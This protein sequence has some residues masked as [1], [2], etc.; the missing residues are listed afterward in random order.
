MHHA[1]R[2]LRFASCFLVVAVAAVSTPLAHAQTIDLSLNVFYAVPSNANSG[3]TWELV[4][5]SSNFGIAT[6]NAKII[7][8]NNDAVAEGPRGNVNGSDGAGFSI[9]EKFPSG[10]FM[11]QEPLLLGSGE[12]QGA[13][14]GV[15]TIAN[16]EP[17]DVGPAVPSLTNPQG[18]PWATGD[19]FSQPAW[20][21]AATLASGT[22]A[23]M[24]TPA[25]MT[26]STG[27]VFTSVGTSTMFGDVATATISTIIRTNFSPGSLP[28][29]FNND[30]FVDA[31][32]YILF[33]KGFPGADYNVWRQNFGT[34]TPP[35]SGGAVPEPASLALVA[36]ALGFV[37]TGRRLGRDN[38]V[39]VC[40]SA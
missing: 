19:A 12:T 22:F 10:I 17:G 15:G 23:E 18:I 2:F 9:F 27:Q 24:F 5:K 39:A 28:G 36:I 4:A 13:F 16:G 37:A 14:Y 3:G 29:D 33:R 6:L 1:L 21:T 32:D 26:G 30:G 8:I 40:K 11:A 25:F 31:A 35:G 34:G 7:N 38:R 20:S